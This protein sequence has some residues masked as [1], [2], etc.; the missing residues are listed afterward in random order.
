MNQ[1]GQLHTAHAGTGSACLEAVQVDSSVGEWLRIGCGRRETVGNPSLIFNGMSGVEAAIT[2]ALGK[3]EASETD[4]STNWQE[5]NPKT[6]EPAVRPY[7]PRLQRSNIG[8]Q[9]HPSVVTLS[10]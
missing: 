7:E 10:D 5:T 9:L 2:A 6:G 3:A 4:A 1:E 8:V